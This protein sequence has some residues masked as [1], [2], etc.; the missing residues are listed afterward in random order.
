MESELHQ[1]FEK[2]QFHLVFQ[3]IVDRAGRIKGA[4]AL[5]RWQHPGKG[6]V[7]PGSFIPLAEETGIIQSIS[8]WA[9]FSAAEHVARWSQR[10][11][12]YVSVN[13][14]AEDFANPELPEVLAS[15]LRR[16]GVTTPSFLKLE[17]TESQ[18]MIDPEGT[19]S[20]MGRLTE[21]GFDLFIDDFGTGNS[22]LGWLKQLP[23][24]TIKIDR[25]FVDECMRSPEDLEFLANIIGLARSRRKSVILEGIATAPQLELLKKLDV[26]GMQGFYFSQPLS[27]ESLG[28]LLSTDPRLPLREGARAELRARL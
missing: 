5:I 14:S 22:S 21:A 4:E 19:V 18:C 7:A 17:I 27:S 10:H 11:G 2:D 3:P 6:L 24:G 1:A 13:L 15:A 23:A 25:L 26:D 8:K 9:L 20:Q 16:A 28:S 12:I